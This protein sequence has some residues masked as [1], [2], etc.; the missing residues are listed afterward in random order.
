MKVTHLSPKKNSAMS[1]VEI[2]I[3]V[4]IIGILAAIAVI[5]ITSV[6]KDAA[7]KSRDRQNAQQLASIC[8]GAAA[9]GLDFVVP[10]DLEATIDNIIIGGTVT[11]GVFAGSE[12]RVP[13]LADEEKLKAMQYLDLMDGECL[14]YN[15]NP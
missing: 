12:F 13:N 8:S 14:T 6:T 10:G 1:L 11:E 3:V 9:A 4:T 2:L 15:P 7:D 5:P